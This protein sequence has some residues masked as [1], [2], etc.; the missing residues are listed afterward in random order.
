[1]SES[2]G[3]APVLR[4]VGAIVAGI[5]VNIVLSLVTDELMY[6][7]G[8]APRVGQRMS[9]PMLAVAAGYRTVYAILASYVIAALAGRRPMLH[10]MI[11]GTL[12]FIVS[13]IGV[14]STWND[15][16]KY[17]PH[18]YPI[19]LVVT[20]LPTAWLGAKLYLTRRAKSAQ[21]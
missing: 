18:W 20:A 14:V 19:S 3:L 4:S 13:I 17:G 7:A 21:S 1:M 16:A 15:V 2:R 9:D 5:V 11:G 8:L 12:G 6:L 10:A